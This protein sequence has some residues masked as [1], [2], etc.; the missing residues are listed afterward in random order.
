MWCQNIYLE[1]IMWDHVT[2]SN[3]G[4]AAFTDSQHRMLHNE[5]D[6]FWFH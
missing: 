6:G 3:E 4:I 5:Y 1:F 2:H